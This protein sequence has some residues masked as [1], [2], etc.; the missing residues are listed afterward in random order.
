MIRDL[1]ARLFNRASSSS[2]NGSPDFATIP[3]PG[4]GAP[5]EAT[6][7]LFTDEQTA[8]L[9]HAI[10]VPIAERAWFCQAL[11]HRSYLQIAESSGLRSNERLEYFG[12]AILD[13]LVGE[14]L[15][16]RYGTVEEGDLTKLRSRLVNR[17]ALTL[18]AR[19]VGLERFIKLNA[20]A[21]LSLQQGNDS[22]LADA[23][24]AILAA[25]FLDSGSRLESARAFLER[26]L[27]RPETVERILSID[28][29][30]KSLLL[31]RA[32][33]DGGAA[34]RYIVSR[35]DGPDHER[36]FTVEVWLDGTLMGEGRG[37]SKK[38]AEQGAAAAALERMRESRG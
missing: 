2:G 17:K 31:E 32:Q 15:F 14:F 5:A 21:E 18:C 23:Y 10:G 25:I 22:M 33:G 13:L 35:E 3:A 19:L 30:Y 29:N 4:L 37:R 34:P 11:T 9:E 7:A 26:T 1:V 12:D 38:E 6:R 8:Q 20:S 16:H 24:E 28:D 36:L 27:L